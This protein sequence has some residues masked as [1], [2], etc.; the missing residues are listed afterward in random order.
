MPKLWDILRNSV[1]NLATHNC[2]V[3]VV[4][5]ETH[6]LLSCFCVQPYV[7]KTCLLSLVTRIYPV[8]GRYSTGHPFL[9]YLNIY[10]LL[11]IYTRYHITYYRTRNPQWAM[12]MSYRCFTGKRSR[13]IPSRSPNMRQAGPNCC[14]WNPE[15]T[16]L[17]VRNVLSNMDV[18]TCKYPCRNL[19]I[20]GN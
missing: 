19:K 2:L 11:D 15:F 1:N 5:I 4:S 14:T 18:A 9:P 6:P 8:T 17:D 20:Q 7:N 13:R 10:L 3:Q 12:V 16:E